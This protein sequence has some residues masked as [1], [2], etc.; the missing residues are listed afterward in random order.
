VESAGGGQ[1][2]RN[3]IENGDFSSGPETGI[4]EGWTRAHTWKNVTDCTI[5]SEGKDKFLRFRRLQAIPQADIK[6]EKA[7]PVPSTARSAEV[8]VRM[9][10]EGLVK[11]KEYDPLPGVNLSVH[12]GGDQKLADAAAVLKEN[13]SWKRL[14]RQSRTPQ[15]AKQLNVSL[16]PHGAA[17]IIDFDE[18][19]V[20]FK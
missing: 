5:V 2:N 1:K 19:A 4:P 10:V 20:E 13:S 12:D 15:G 14:T 6:P 11:G 16:G 17:G 3:V 7:I 9:R 18:V 8:T